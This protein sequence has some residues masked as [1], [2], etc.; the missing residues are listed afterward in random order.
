MNAFCN[1]RR[2]KNKDPSRGI[3]SFLFF[4]LS[5]RL[6][7]A[8]QDAP[9]FYKSWELWENILRRDPGVRSLPISRWSRVPG[10]I[11]ERMQMAFGREE[12]A[13]VNFGHVVQLLIGSV[14][15][16]EFK[17]SVSISKGGGG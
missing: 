7:K 14:G 10:K 15:R 16:E 11:T 1:A 17:E 12:K 4:S 3:W 13:E 6:S 5:L 8:L 2:V 9:A